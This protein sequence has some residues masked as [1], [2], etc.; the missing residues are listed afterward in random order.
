MPS[1]LLQEHPKGR[2]SVTG[3]SSGGRTVIGFVGHTE[4]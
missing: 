4:S 3:A 2:G 1:W